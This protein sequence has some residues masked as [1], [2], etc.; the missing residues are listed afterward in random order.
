MVFMLHL[1]LDAILCIQVTHDRSSPSVLQFPPPPFSYYL[2]RDDC[3]CKNYLQPTAPTFDVIP[4]RGN[5]RSIELPHMATISN[6]GIYYRGERRGYLA[7]RLK[8][9]VFLPCDAYRY[10]RLIFNSPSTV[11]AFSTARPH[12]IDSPRLREYV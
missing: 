10:R 11:F 2:P 8:K 6:D 1:S 12:N 4:S 7:L 9:Y 3:L 5:G